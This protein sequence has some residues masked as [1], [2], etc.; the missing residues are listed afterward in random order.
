MED[1][2]RLVNDAHKL[3]DPIGAL[4]KLAGP[5]AVAVRTMADVAL[6]FQRTFAL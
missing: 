5:G 3:D 2:G 1:L 6:A 4:S